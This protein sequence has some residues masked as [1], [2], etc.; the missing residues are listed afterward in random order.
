MKFGPCGWKSRPETGLWQ[1]KGHVTAPAEGPASMPWRPD[2]GLRFVISPIAAPR[3]PGHGGSRT[4]QEDGAGVPRPGRMGVLMTA[5]ALRYGAIMVAAGVGI[6]ILAALNARLGG[7]IAAPAA[8]AVVLFAVAFL[9][10]VL[11]MLATGSTPALAR[12]PDQPRYLFIAGL[13]VCFYVPSVTWVAPRFGLGNAITCVLLGQLLAATVIDQFG[14]M[15]AIVRQVTPMRASGLGLMA[16]GI[17]LV[18]KG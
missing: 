1:A 17:V 11:V 2:Q 15:G 9:G 6:P 14:L 16:L 12:L 8:A 18:Q 13:F 5:E 3:A 7:L 10:A 4:G